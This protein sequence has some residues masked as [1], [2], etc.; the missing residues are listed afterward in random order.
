MKK[1]II[2]YI[3]VL[4][5][6]NSCVLF[7]QGF[8]SLVPKDDVKGINKKA[9]IIVNGDKVNYLHAAKK[10][11]GEGNVSIKYGEITLTCDKITVHTDK[12]IGICEGNV[13]IT[14]PGAV[15]TGQKV[16]YDFINETGRVINGDIEANPFYASAKSVDKVSLDKVILKGGEF[17]TCDLENPHYRIEAK[18]ITLYI[19]DKVVAKHVLFYVGKI[20][21]L[22]IPYYIQ[23]IRDLKTKINVL[24]GYKDEWGYYVLSSYRYYFNDNSKGYLKLD[25]REKRGL[26]GGIDYSYDVDKLGKGLARFYYGQENN[27]LTIKKSGKIE[28]RWRVQYRH[29]IDLAPRTTG[30]IEINKLSDRDI[31]KDYFYKEYE[32]GNNAPNYI[33]IINAE[34]NYNFEILI[35]KRINDFFTVTQKLPEVTLEINNQKLGD[36]FFYYENDITFTNFS[37]QYD[38]ELNQND[39]NVIRLDTYN[40]LS[41]LARLLPGVFATPYIATR[42]TFYSR[43]KWGNHNLLRN[44]YEYGINF[45]TKLYKVFDFQSQMVDVTQLRHVFSPTIGFHHRNQPSISPSNLFQLDAIDSID[46][47]NSISFL[48]ENKLQTKRKSGDG[49]RSVDLIRFLVSTEYLYRYKKGNLS[50]K[51]VGKFTD[52]RYQ[53]EIRPYEWLYAQTDIT[54]SMKDYTVKTATTD[55]VFDIE[56]KLKFGMGHIY[57]HSDTSSASQFTIEANYK[58]NKDWAIRAYERFDTHDKKWQEQEYAIYRDLHCWLGELTFNLREGDFAVW[59]IFRLKAF[60]EVPIGFKRTYHRPTPGSER[61]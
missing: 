59:M 57:E 51:G 13:K 52:M 14:Q 12:K 8:P 53:L 23:P 42:Q 35:K 22:Y 18:E 4:T 16:E 56:D 40:S 26:A 29:R 11:I 32:E 10:I 48:V 37:K 47:D 30:I 43:N 24:P 38:D 33:S 46:Y 1:K 50:F 21:I 58:I 61:L 44:I 54:Q 17:T 5:F 27:A 36:T 60:P 9:P 55:L 45:T 20:P 41:Y 31:I 2:F 25:Y 15:F 3:L 39:E 34:R 28:D 7:A 6:I 49:W 19:D